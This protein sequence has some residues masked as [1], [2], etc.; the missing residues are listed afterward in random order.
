MD[1][2]RIAFPPGACDSY[3]CFVHVLPSEARC[4]QHRLRRALRAGLGDPGTDFIQSIAHKF[5]YPMLSSK[6][7]LK[8]AQQTR[9]AVTVQQE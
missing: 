3:L 7:L 4:V 8:S 2:A 6:P 9:L 1:V 5:F